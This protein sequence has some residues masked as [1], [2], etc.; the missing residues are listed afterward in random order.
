[1]RY[2]SNN[3][4]TLLTITSSIFESITIND[5]GAAVLFRSQ[6]Q[7]IQNKIISRYCNNLHQ[8]LHGQ[9]CYT[10]T[11]ASS[12]AKNHLIDASIIHR[13][14]D[15]PGLSS[16]FLSQGN[17]A[18]SNVN[19]SSYSITQRLY[20]IY[21]CQTDVYLK[22]SNFVNNTISLTYGSVHDPLAK[23]C[24]YYLSN[25]N[26]IDLNVANG[27]IIFAHSI[28]YITDSNLINNTEK[29]NHIFFVY[30]ST[31]RIECINC[32]LENEI[33]ATN[34]GTLTIDKTTYEMLNISCAYIS[35]TCE[36]N[37]H[38]ACLKCELNLSRI[39]FSWIIVFILI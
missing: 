15:L 5:I 39:V 6:G 32:Y 11:S 29:R 21:A 7:I 4:N 37:A 14:E 19:L 24:V 9:Y 17:V 34:S 36:I 35:R 18:V 33:V 3:Q 8:D 10:Y 25:L 26:Y 22:C 16:F 20:H 28:L 27:G 31:S 30:D 13:N 23:S 38:S 12:T 1:M 2:D